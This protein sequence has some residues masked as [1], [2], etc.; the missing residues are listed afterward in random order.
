TSSVI[1]F[2]FGAPP[3]AAEPLQ[4]SDRAL[5]KRHTPKTW[6]PRPGPGSDGV[7]QEYSTGGAP[8]SGG[9]RGPSGRPADE[10]EDLP[11]RAFRPAL[12][13]DQRFDRSAAHRDILVFDDVHKAYRADMPVLK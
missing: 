6:S 4:Q 5:S 7:M 9:T 2:P 1:K 13:G 3:G 12:R 8:G 10:L 11:T